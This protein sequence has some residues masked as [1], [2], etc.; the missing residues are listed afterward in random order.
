MD[1]TISRAFACRGTNQHRNSVQHGEINFAEDLLEKAVANHEAS[2]LG[3]DGM[4]GMD[5][6]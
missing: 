3:M 4:D 1:K 6:L 5:G 2:F